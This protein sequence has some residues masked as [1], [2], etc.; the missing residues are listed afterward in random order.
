MTS[1]GLRLHGDF[2]SNGC[3]RLYYQKY[4]L[5]FSKNIH[6]FNCKMNFNYNTVATLQWITFSA[7]SM[8]RLVL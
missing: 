8:V 5:T 7:Q 4:K 6:F 3:E 2:T 1:T